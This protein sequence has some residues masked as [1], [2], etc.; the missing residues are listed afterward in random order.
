MSEDVQGNQRL[1]PLCHS[2]TKIRWQQTAAERAH[3]AGEGGGLHHGHHAAIPSEK[4]TPKVQK[5]DRKE[6]RRLVA[7]GAL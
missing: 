3:N 6:C 1:N 2:Y 7:Y 4:K 5:V